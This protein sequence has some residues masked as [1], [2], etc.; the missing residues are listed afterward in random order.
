MKPSAH[1][2]EYKFRVRW[3]MDKF[4]SQGQ[5]PKFQAFA[6]FPNFVLVFILI[7]INYVIKP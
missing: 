1:K 4:L 2:Y 3:D 7:V 5:C 6:I